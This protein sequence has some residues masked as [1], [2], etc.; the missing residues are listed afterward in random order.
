MPAPSTRRIASPLFAAGALGAV[1]LSLLW[2]PSGTEPAVEEALS[3][4]LPAAQ[5]PLG[6]HLSRPIPPEPEIRAALELLESG[7]ERWREGAHLEGALAVDDALS[8][9]P[10]MDDWRPLLLAELLAPTGDTA[11]VRIALEG[12][13]PLSELPSRWGWQIQVEALE[14]ADDPAAAAR[15][16]RAAARVERDAGREGAKWLAAGRA[17]LSAGDSLAARDDLWAAVRMGPSFAAAREAARILDRFAGAPGPADELLLGRVLLAAG[18]WDPAHTRLRPFLQSGG[19][20]AAE[21]DELTVGLGRALFELRRH[22]DAEGLLAPLA[23]GSSAT[24]HT[25]SALYWTGRSALA[26]GATSAAEDSFRRLARLAPDSPL[27]EEAFHLLLT[28]ELSTGFGPRARGFLDELLTVAIRNANTELSVVQLGT[29]LYLGGEYQAAARTFDAFRSSSRREA[30]RQQA[31]YWAAL[32]LERAGDPA[33]ARERLQ[34]VHRE[35][36]LSMYGVFAGERADLPVLPAGL[37]EGPAPIPGL[38]TELRN[39]LIRVRVHQLVPTPGSLVFETDR[40]TRYFA[41]LGSARY[42]LAEAMI[43]GGLPLQG[44]VLGRDLHR[45]E[46]EWNLRLLRI[47]HP[48]PHRDI[49]VRE[50]SARGLDPFFVAG[51]IRQESM[52]HAEIRSVAGAVGLMQLMPAT[53]REVAGTL[54][55]RYSPEVLNDPEVNVRLGTTYLASM[56]SRFQ[57]RAEDALSAYNAG[58]SR[59]LQWRQ[60]PTYMDRDVFME[61][62]PF[63][64]TRHYVKVVQQYARVYTA[65]YGCGDFDPCHG[66]SYPAAVDRSPVAG[67]A[68]RASLTRD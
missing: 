42:D 3:R 20:A 58:P 66:L 63:Q 60:T 18:A 38:E 32:A 55:I 30:G 43:H 25:L 51:L 67:G 48:F 56:L 65:L 19:L 44:I 61:H 37:V 2:S 4:E 40:V 23:S 15:V 54:G 10:T 39:A 53:A 33:G 22:A 12:V 64:E 7:M 34:Q 14:A 59:I 47:V 52:F 1:A 6:P 31:G 68:P 21:R 28:R 29:T 16:A 49:I 57:G 9:L 50:A 26:R 41:A 17:A 27:A 45:E 8:R 11:A 35:D 24:P 36:P 13:D 62:I 5:D 46:G